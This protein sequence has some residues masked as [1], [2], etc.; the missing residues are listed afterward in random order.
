[1]R[2]RGIEQSVNYLK[3]PIGLALDKNSQEWKAVTRVREIRNMI[4]H[5]NGRLRDAQGEILPDY[6]DALKN[7]R[8]Q[9]S[10]GEEIVLEEGF[11]FQTVEILKTYFKLI[12]D[13]IQE[14]E[15]QRQK[16]S[17]G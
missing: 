8:Y 16:T 12:E 6:R 15:K 4:V 11:V 5:R 17:H 10:E 2:G 9:N 7:L 13:S 14:N 1:V 3:K